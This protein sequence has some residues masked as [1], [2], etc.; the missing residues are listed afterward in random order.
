VEAACV[1]RGVGND[2]SL[3]D[4][5]REMV[6]HRGGRGEVTSQVCRHSVFCSA[7]SSYVYVSATAESATMRVKPYSG[8]LGR[9]SLLILI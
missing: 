2:S 5:C 4:E 1:W 3:N 6:R 8:T 9:L 7:G